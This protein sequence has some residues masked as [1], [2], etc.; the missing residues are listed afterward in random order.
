ME[1][2]LA[3]DIKKK[4]KKGFYRYIGQKRQAKDSILSLVNEKREL[5]TTAMDKAEV[6]KEFFASILTGRQD[7]CIFYVPEACI[8]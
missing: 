3:R 7:S 2:N 6:L 5:S 4:N 8:P 1:F